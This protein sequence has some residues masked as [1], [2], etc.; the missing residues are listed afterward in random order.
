MK[1]LEAITQFNVNPLQLLRRLVRTTSNALGRNEEVYYEPRL[2]G[3][4][5]Q[6][7]VIEDTVD[8][9]YEELFGDDYYLEEEQ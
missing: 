2:V 4:R 5:L 6:E 7:V 3:A 1:I 8:V 9:E